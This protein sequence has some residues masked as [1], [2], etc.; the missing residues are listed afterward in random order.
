MGETEDL[1]EE[2]VTESR[3]HIADI[4]NDL[5][6]IEAAGED[7]DKASIDRVFRAAH[8]IKG[9]AKFLDLS[10]IGDLAHIMEDV[11]NLIRSGKIS[12]DRDVAGALLQGSD[13]LKLMFDNVD[14]S[15]DMDIHQQIDVLQVILNKNTREPQKKA[16]QQG[17]DNAPQ[18][19][20]LFD[21]TA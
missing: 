20:P 8:S 1:I 13:M 6:N 19:I 3:E 16:G 12:T 15:N 11:L 9:S 21:V 4:E 5:I 2:F 17:R 18:A 7:M 10:K 14:A